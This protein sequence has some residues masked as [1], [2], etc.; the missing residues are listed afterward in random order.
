MCYKL[1]SCL[2]HCE[3]AR[4]ATSAFLSRCGIALAKAAAETKP[5]QTIEK[6]FSDKLLNDIRLAET[7]L[8]AFLE[9]GSKTG[10]PARVLEEPVQQKPK[11]NE[12][13]G[14]SSYGHKALTRR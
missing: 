4:K 3:H 7:K 6:E 11:K 10:L 13:A 9:Q 12:A 1:V 14:Q 5:K 8:R 2:A